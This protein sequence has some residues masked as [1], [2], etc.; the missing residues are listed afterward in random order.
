M[1]AL[2]SQLPLLRIGPCDLTDYEPA[3]LTTC[4]RSA[5]SRAGHADWWI[6]ED[7]GR[8]V[9]AYLQTRYPHSVITLSELEEKIRRTL[10]KIGYSD[11]A[12][13][14]EI[15]PP[16]VRLNLREIAREASGVELAFFRLLEVRLSGL[17]DSGVRRIAL[18]CAKEAV[19]ILCAAKHWSQDCRRLEGDITRFL[20]R[21]FADQS[22]A[23]WQ[24]RLEA[25]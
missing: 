12:A 7:I 3:W 10:Q 2:P 20:H 19:K 9:L 6:A 13:A 1:I 23:G 5:A 4:I 15:E 8:G 25:A 14:V 11:I 21:R 16:V 24:V 18:H 17:A 22:D